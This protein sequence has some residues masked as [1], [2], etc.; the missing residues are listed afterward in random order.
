MN[1]REVIIKSLVGLGQSMPKENRQEIFGMLRIWHSKRLE[2]RDVGA[3]PYFCGL[4]PDVQKAVQLIS[5]SLKK[6]DDETAKNLLE[7][8]PMLT[9][10]TESALLKQRDHEDSIL[11][12]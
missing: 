7:Y 6:I 4:N 1:E 8:A 12:T 3:N 5:S 11:G 2:S 10:V 9:N